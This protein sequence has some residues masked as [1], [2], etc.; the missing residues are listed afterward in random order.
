MRHL[1]FCDGV[2]RCEFNGTRAEA[3]AWAIENCDGEVKVIS[4]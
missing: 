1:I 2:F 4:L 3:I